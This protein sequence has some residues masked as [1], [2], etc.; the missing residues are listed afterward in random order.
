MRV[1]VVLRCFLGIMRG[2]HCMAVRDMRM[3]AG[4]LV[5]AFLVMFCRLGVVLGRVFMMLGG[6]FVVLDLGVSGHDDLP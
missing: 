3:M 5:V 2:V 6:C 1:S 4:L